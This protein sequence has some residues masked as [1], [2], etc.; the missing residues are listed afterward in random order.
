[1]TS[2]AARKFFSA[3]AAI[4]SPSLSVSLAPPLSF[5][6]ALA[7]SDSQKIAIKALHTNRICLLAFHASHNCKN[8]THTLYTHILRLCVYH[9]MQSVRELARKVCSLSNNFRLWFRI[10]THKML[11]RSQLNAAKLCGNATLKKLN[12]NSSSTWHKRGKSRPAK[13]SQLSSR[14]SSSF[15]T[16][17]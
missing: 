4:P 16:N 10:S 7:S 17:E 14:N 5:W 11:R 8:N 9:I 6:P 2:P 13:R 1:M 15:G 3:N 12:M